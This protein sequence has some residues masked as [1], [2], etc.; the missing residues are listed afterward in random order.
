MTFDGTVEITLLS[1]VLSRYSKGYASEITPGDA[2]MSAAAAAPAYS[3]EEACSSA[4][5]GVN[6]GPY[7]PT[8]VEIGET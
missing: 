5:P 1:I 7:D 8:C 6:S 4:V 2:V 3:A